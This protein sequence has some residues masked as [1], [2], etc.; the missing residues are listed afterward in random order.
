M[1]RA[2]PPEGMPIDEACK[3]ID[4]PL[5]DSYVTAQAAAGDLDKL[6]RMV[7]SLRPD[8]ERRLAHRN[9]MRDALDALI[10]GCL[11][12]GEYELWARPGSPLADSRR[13]P[14]SAVPAL[15]FDYEHRRAASHGP[16]LLDIRLRLPPTASVKRQH[17][18]PSATALQAAALAIAKTY[19]P[20]DPPTAPAWKMALEAH[21]GKSVTREV[22]RQ[23]L[24]Q[25]APHLQRQPGQKRNRR[26]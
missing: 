21:L 22:A 10:R 11:E 18:L 3:L 17:K 7:L 8:Q 14:M 25:W 19:E 16:P 24:A 2:A 1:A 9:K 12:R 5:W 26:S 23:A 6:R 20:G 15:E 4:G 13:I